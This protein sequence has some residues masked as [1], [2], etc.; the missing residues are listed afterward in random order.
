V[1]NSALVVGGTGPTGP[2]ILDGLLRRGYDVS[3]F[4]RGSHEPPD[5]P[6][7]RHIHGDPHFPDTI[8]AAVGHGEYDV[9]LAAYGRTA[10]LAEAF[11]GRAGRFLAI[12][13][14]P[15]YAG[16][17]EPRRLSPSGAPIPLREDAPSALTIP[18]QGSPALTFAHRMIH[19]E[20]AVFAAHPDATYFVYPIVYGPR[21]VWP[22]EW[23]VVKRISDGRERLLIPD[24]GLAIHSRVAARNAADVVLRSIDRPEVAKGQRYN[25]GDDVQY[26]IRQWVELLVERLGAA[27][28]IV[29]VPSA[30]APWVKAMYVPTS[31]SLGDHNLLDTAKARQELG[32]RDVIDVRSAIDELLAWFRDN[33]VDPARSPSFVDCFDY[34]LEDALLESWARVVRRLR[35]AHG[36]DLP[37][38]VHPMP[39]PKLAGG[40]ADQK[41]R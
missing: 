7:V 15:R 11:R 8:R 22:W 33:P 1:V 38:D 23:S 16:F 35:A 25:V 3:V 17:N 20:Q 31:T 32:Y 36:W 21:T 5:L 19:T 10:L 2:H 29:S 6:D 40:L 37:A 13:G 14:A 41:G 4:H 24:E 26:S 30:V 34:A 39:H 12:G 9:V 18:A 27:A 28:E